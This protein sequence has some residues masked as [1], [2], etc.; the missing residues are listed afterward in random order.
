M[1]LANATVFSF[2]GSP[3][4]STLADRALAA[5]P[6]SL[7]ICDIALLSNRNAAANLHNRPFGFVQK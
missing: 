7:F 2:T 5:N 1:A 3:G 4:V 6:A